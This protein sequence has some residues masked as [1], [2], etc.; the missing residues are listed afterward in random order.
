MDQP[1]Q[2]SNSQQ[3]QQQYYVQSTMPN[4]LKPISA[5]GYFGWQIVFN[6]PI[7]GFICLLICAIGVKNKNLRSFARSYFCVYI[8]MIIVFIFL[9]TAGASFLAAIFAQITSFLTKLG[10]I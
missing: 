8:V 9:I 2:N 10:V 3:S 6:I 1:N 5:W 7:L 4:N